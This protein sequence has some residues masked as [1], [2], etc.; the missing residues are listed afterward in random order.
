MALLDHQTLRRIGQDA[1]KGGKADKIPI[2][3]F[4]KKKLE[5]GAKVER[6][7]TDCPTVAREIARDH[8]TEDIEYYTKL[9]KMEKH[10]MITPFDAFADE[11]EKISFAKEKRAWKS[12]IAPTVGGALI[13]GAMAPQGETLSGAAK[14]AAGGA[15]LTHG[16]KH[17]KRFHKAVK[18]HAE[19]AGIKNMGD[20][21]SHAMDTE[22][23]KV[24]S[25]VGKKGWE[26]AAK[27][28]LG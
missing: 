25:E 14:G 1:I 7:H 24:L 21:A 17:G 13:G 10:A 15:L 22:K 9:K 26:D 8:L 12:Y 28:K 18:P 23:R 4:P 2:S 27:L 6:E 3:A 19:A 5:Q 16:Y 20:V 11:L